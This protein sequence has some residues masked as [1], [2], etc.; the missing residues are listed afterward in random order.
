LRTKTGSRSSICQSQITGHESLRLRR[1]YMLTRYYTAGSG[2]FLQV[3][4]GYDYK[5]TDPMS[6][7][8]YGYVRENLIKFYD[9]TGEWVID[10]EEGTPGYAWTTQIIRIAQI[11]VTG[12]NTSRGRYKGTAWCFIERLKQ[13]GMSTSRDNP[14]H[15]SQFIQTGQGPKIVFDAE[16][17]EGDYGSTERKKGVDHVSL[18][19]GFV[20]N[21]MKWERNGNHYKA[22]AGI[23]WMASTLVHE[24]A[25]WQTY[26]PD[27]IDHTPESHEGVREDMIDVG[28][29]NMQSFENWYHE[30]RSILTSNLP[31]W[32]KLRMLQMTKEKEA[33]K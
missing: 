21:I 5:L 14:Y 19:W 22:E 3:D 27:G 9:G 25:H 16:L 24:T 33:R 6:F 29:A 15:P 7:N 8:L 12:K 28:A 32:A 17:K 20:M 18:N 30:N 1:I 13:E 31:L 26:S 4:P 23:I 11:M 10:Y 2:R